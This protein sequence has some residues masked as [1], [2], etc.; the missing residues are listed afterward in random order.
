M[1]LPEKLG[2]AAARSVNHAS[3]LSE[4]DNARVR[5]NVRKH[6][7]EARLSLMPLIE[8]N[9]KDS[10]AQQPCLLFVVKKD[11]DDN[12]QATEQA[13]K[14]PTGISLEAGQASLKIYRK[15]VSKIGAALE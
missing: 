12:S 7:P 3:Q 2:E 1:A 11:N 10:Q 6:T 5:D 15:R 4:Q 13:V 14:V 9:S 8:S